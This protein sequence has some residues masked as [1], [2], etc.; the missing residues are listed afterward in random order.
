MSQMKRQPFQGS[1]IDEE[2]VLSDSHETEA[3]LSD[4]HEAEEETA[5]KEQEPSQLSQ[6]RAED[7]R[8]E[9]RTPG[10]S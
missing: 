3:V 9:L 10:T 1:A 7:L 4:S 8:D 2:A 6:G 5:T